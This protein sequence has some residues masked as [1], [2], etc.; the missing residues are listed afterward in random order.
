MAVGGRAEMK[1]TKDWG[2]L[3]TEWMVGPNGRELYALV[4]RPH[5]DAHCCAEVL[6]SLIP[7]EELVRSAN[8]GIAEQEK[9]S[10]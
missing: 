9:G 7:A 3:A 1:T 8:R 4:I 2:V 5:C 6:F 10:C